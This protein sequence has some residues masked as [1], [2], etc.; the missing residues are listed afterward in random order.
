MCIRDRRLAWLL[1]LVD[2]VGNEVTQ[3]FAGAGAAQVD[4]G[5]VRDIEHAGVATHLVVLVELRA[6]AERHVPAAEI[7]HL[8]AEGAVGVIEDRLERHRGAWLPKDRHYP[9]LLYTS[10]CV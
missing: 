3:E 10:R 9:C 2:V 1:H 6:V 8:R 4:H 7:D 5:H